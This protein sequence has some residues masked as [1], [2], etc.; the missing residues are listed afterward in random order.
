MQASR[1]HLILSEDPEDRQIL[2]RL[3]QAQRKQHG[4]LVGT[5]VRVGKERIYRGDRVRLGETSSTYGIVKGTFGEVRHIDPVTKV[6]AIRLDSG[7]HKLA[8]LRHYKG[9][10]LGY[11]IL[12]TQ[13]RE[14]E[15]RYAYVLSRGLYGRQGAALQLSRAKVETH[16]NTYQLEREEEAMV[17]L[18]RKMSREKHRDFARVVEREGLER[19]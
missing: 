16:L 4:N 19:E 18:A 3:A 9:M 12:E 14:V 17:E 2:N 7:K 1:D 13:A 8:N 10:E 15:T 6:A 11:C 5:G